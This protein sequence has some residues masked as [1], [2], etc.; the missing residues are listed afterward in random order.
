METILIC[1]VISEPPVLVE[2]L[3]SLE[4]VKGS[5]AVFACKVAGSA[6]FKVTW[7]KNKKLI[8]SSPKY[9]IST[10][11]Q[12]VGLEIQDCEPEDVGTYQCV[13]N[14]E[15][16]SFKLFSLLVP[17]AFVK[18][19]E[20]VSTVLGDC[21]VT[22]SAPLT[23]SWFHNGQEIKSGPNYIISCDEYTCKLRVPSI[24]MSDSGK[25][26]C[27]AVNAAGTSETSASMNVTGQ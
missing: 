24:K 17:P 21:K 8:K 4:V 13:V 3:T 15:V 14:N 1:L 18:K 7:L 2:E 23:T 27:K 20:N 19:I 9:W 16:G 6:L 26:T 22:G 25:Y 5:T 12:N 10:D 11:G